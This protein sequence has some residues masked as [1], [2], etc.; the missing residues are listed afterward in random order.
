MARTIASMCVPIFGTEP[1]CAMTCAFQHTAQ[2]NRR[3]CR[4]RNSR[5]PA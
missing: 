4:M 1:F 3:R 5:L 2:V